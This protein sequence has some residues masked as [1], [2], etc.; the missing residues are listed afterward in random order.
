MG[1]E[2]GSRKLTIGVCVDDIS[3]CEIEML[4]SHLAVVAKYLGGHTKYLGNRPAYCRCHGECGARLGGDDEGEWRSGGGAARA[5][6]GVSRS[7]AALAATGRCGEQ[8]K[9]Q[10]LGMEPRHGTMYVASAPRWMRCLA[11]PPFTFQRRV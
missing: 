3:P 1:W 8:R 2:S 11:R 7:R 6:R 9:G 10:E 5:R 4:V